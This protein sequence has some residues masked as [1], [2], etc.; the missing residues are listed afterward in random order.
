M[1]GEENIKLIANNYG[2]EAQSRQCIEELSEL[3]QAIY[4]DIRVR[5]AASG[6]SEIIKPIN[7][8]SDTGKKIVEEIADVENDFYI[9][10]PNSV[11]EEIETHS[12]DVEEQEEY[13]QDI[14]N[15]KPEWW[16]SLKIK[17]TGKD[18][19]YQCL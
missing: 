14:L 11:L 16:P 3:I 6:N 1:S 13:F 17:I 15:E 19:K 18:R 9:D 8:L 10:P 12:D 4:K 7:K 5:T 2:Y